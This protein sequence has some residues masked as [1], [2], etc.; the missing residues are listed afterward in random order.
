M[1]LISFSVAN[2]RSFHEE[3]T[4]K[5][6]QK[7]TAA[8]A[9][10][11]PNGS[12][13]SNLFMAMLSF[14]NYI[15]NSTKFRENTQIFEPFLLNENSA[16]EP[17]KFIVEFENADVI[18]KFSFASKNGKIIEEKL[19]HRSAKEG[20]NYETVYSRGSIKNNIYKKTGFTNEILSTTRPDAL[21]LTRAYETNNKIAIRVF[22][23][24]SS[25]K[26]INQ[27]RIINLTAKSIIENDEYKNKVLE[28][29]KKADLAIQDISSDA[30]TMPDS[31]YNK[32]P[33]ADEYKSKVN[34]IGYEVKTTH[35]IRDDDGNV[36]SGIQL[37]MNT[38]ESKG[39]QRIFELAFPVLETLEEGNILYIDEFET[40]LHPAE[41]LL[42]INLFMSSEN[43]NGA[44]LI[45][46]THNTQ[47]MNAVG[48]NNIFLIAKNLKEESVI[49]QIK[50]VR[51]DDKVLEKKYIKGYFGAVPNIREA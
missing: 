3:Q 36:V 43:A 50:S 35:L 5:F 16:D 12:G 27:E 33:L 10:F 49:G 25:F 17:T 22:E 11:G 42:I 4:I 38:H 15:L 18:Y 26:F 7:Y 39:T 19:S 29:L 28:L 32:L 1:K 34:R 40:Y 30:I 6:N 31:I 23:F 51:S 48:K 13:K 24:L 21:V 41:C 37:R 20:S 47:I 9:I 46:N 14:R 2:F 8:N 44:Q 45:V